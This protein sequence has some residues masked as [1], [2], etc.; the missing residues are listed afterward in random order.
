VKTTLVSAGRYKVEG[1]P[2]APLD[3]EARMEM[4]KRVDSL[5]SDFVIDVA[6][7][8]S[9]MQLTV[10]EQFGEGRLVTARDA[11]ARG[12]IDGIKSFDEV[13]SEAG[14]NSGELARSARVAYLLESERS[15]RVRA[16]EN[17]RLRNN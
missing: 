4:Q 2:F 1:S 8:R 16:L 7:H 10:R 6:K 12:M 15:D 11:K 17:Y 3:E 9:K 5:H 13:L 14:T